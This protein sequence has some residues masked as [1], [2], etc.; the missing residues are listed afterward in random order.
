M[1]L[2]FHWAMHY[3]YPKSLSNDCLLTHDSDFPDYGQ[4]TWFNHVDFPDYPQLQVGQ[5]YEFEIYA[6]SSTEFVIK[7]DELYQQ[8]SVEWSGSLE[9]VTWLAI[10][11]NAALDI[12]QVNIC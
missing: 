6:L 11:N 12:H 8:A 9:E 5:R 2:V 4:C 1:R 10:E 3:T 7:V